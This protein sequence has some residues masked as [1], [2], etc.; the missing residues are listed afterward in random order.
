MCEKGT[1]KHVFFENHLDDLRE[2]KQ[3]RKN[4]VRDFI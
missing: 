3:N 4:H 1:K 2:K